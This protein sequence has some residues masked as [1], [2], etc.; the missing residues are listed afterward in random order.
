MAAPKGNQYGLALSDPEIRQKAYKSFCDHLAKGRAIE[1]WFY[2]DE[3]NSCCWLTMLRYM[4]NEDEFKPIQKIIAKAKGYQYWENVVAESAIGVNEKA[5]TA[6]LQMIM[7]NKYGWDKREDD[8]N[9]NQKVV[10]EV[11]YQCPNSQVEVL[12]KTVSE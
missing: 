8:K 4:E 10:F 1:S 6:S 11:N 9:Q 12:P 5:N 7:R 2:E 3:E